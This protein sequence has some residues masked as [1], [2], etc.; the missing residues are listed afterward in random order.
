MSVSAG[1]S[2]NYNI[3]LSFDQDARNKY[4]NK[5]INFDFIITVEQVGG[6]GNGGG[7]VVI[8]G[9]GGGSG[10]PPGLSIYNESDINASST[11]AT[12]TWNTSY[13]AT[14]RVIYDVI[15]GVFDFSAGEMS[16]GYADYRDG[17]DVYG[18]GKGT[19]HKITLT[20][21][22]S[23]TTYYYRCVSHASPATISQEHSFAT[24]TKEESL[25]KEEAE[26]DKEKEEGIIS[27]GETEGT[28]MDSGTG[29]FETEE[30]IGVIPSSDT[31]SG[32]V[33]TEG[34]TTE[35]EESSLEGDLAKIARETDETSGKFGAFGANLVSFLKS[36]PWWIL[37]IIAILIFLG[38]FFTRRKEK[39]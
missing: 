5:T 14:S 2:N 32:T 6:N 1:E 27:E 36:I 3:I 26:K 31:E 23:G 39:K 28:G 35:G 33:I 24:L 21:L 25:K 16:Y 15:S 37:I 10:T 7:Q 9:G 12:I 20:G 13:D 4:Q 17:D 29:T 34:G 38:L 19:Y 18:S 30:D 11:S 8:P 22:T